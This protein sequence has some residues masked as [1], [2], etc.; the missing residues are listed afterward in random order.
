MSADC[1]MGQPG[2][3]ASTALAQPESRG[4]RPTLTQY[5]GT[6]SA[7]WLLGSMEARVGNC[8]G[9]QRILCAEADM[10]VALCTHL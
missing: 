8:R 10:K 6:C 7:P 5:P 2:F 1:W 9:G 4:A 3:P